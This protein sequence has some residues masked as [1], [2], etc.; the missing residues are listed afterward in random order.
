MCGLL[1]SRNTFEA[2]RLLAG[3][4]LTRRNA[5]SATAAIE[6]TLI[7]VGRAASCLFVQSRLLGL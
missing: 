7:E 1:K 3:Y 6:Y 2:E 4:V 5:L